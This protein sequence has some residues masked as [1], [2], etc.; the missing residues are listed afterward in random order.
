MFNVRDSHVPKAKHNDITEWINLQVDHCLLDHPI[1]DEWKLEY[2]SYLLM[3]RTMM[4]RFKT[5]I[6][7]IS[8]VVTL[9]Q[10]KCLDPQGCITKDKV[11]DL[12]WQI[13]PAA[14]DSNPS[15]EWYIGFPADSKDSERIG[16]LILE[17]QQCCEVGA[18]A[19]SVGGTRAWRRRKYTSS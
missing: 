13:K 18:A 3:L 15:P 17:S 16:G 1:D 2:W 6:S 7:C 14:R 10:R 4:R 19:V 12:M 9:T 11:V 8:V 5:L